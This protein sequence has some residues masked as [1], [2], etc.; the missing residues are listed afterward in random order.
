MPLANDFDEYS[1][2]LRDRFGNA[3]RHGP[4]HSGGKR[5]GACLYRHLQGKT[6]FSVLPAYRGWYFR[7]GRSMAQCSQ[8]RKLPA[9]ALIHLR[10]ASPSQRN[11]PSHKGGCRPKRL[12]RYLPDKRGKHKTCGIRSTGRFPMEARRYFCCFTFRQRGLIPGRC[13]PGP[14]LKS[15][16]HSGQTGSRGRGS[17]SFAHRDSTPTDS[18]DGD[19]GYPPH[20]G[21][22]CP[23]YRRPTF[24]HSRRRSRRGPGGFRMPL[25]TGSEKIVQQ[26]P[27][28]LVR[29]L[30]LSPKGQPPQTGPAQ[31]HGLFLYKE[32]RSLGRW[33]KKAYGDENDIKKLPLL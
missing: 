23:P 25:L 10:A 7:A 21:C 4:V 2:L 18:P 22:R 12:I 3:L 19:S 1:H 13:S 16:A 31:R 6:G 32:N 24:S 5:A 17:P 30:L 8:Y 9:E 14:V 11:G 28:Q 27:S 20:G 26:V 33:F 15:T 29:P